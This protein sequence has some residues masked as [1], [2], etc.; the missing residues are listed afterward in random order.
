[1]VFRSNHGKFK[2][3]KQEC[4]EFLRKFKISKFLWSNIETMDLQQILDHGCNWQVKLFRHEVS[5]ELFTFL[6]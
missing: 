2:D 5:A 6:V 4:D 3:L 1:M